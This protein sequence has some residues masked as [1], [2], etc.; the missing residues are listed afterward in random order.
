MLSCSI[1]VAL[2]RSPPIT[3]SLE[4][5]STKN[6]WPVTGTRAQ[7]RSTP[8][9]GARTTHQWLPHRAAPGARTPVI[10]LVHDLD[11]RV[12]DAA[13]GELLRE[14]TIDPNRDYQPPG[15]DRYARWRK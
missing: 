3:A 11:V 9:P 2:P 4:P 10:L 8:A 14:L 1:S 12:I 5:G 7:P 6:C 13:T 15:R